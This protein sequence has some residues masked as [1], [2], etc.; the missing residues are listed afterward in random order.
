MLTNEQINKQQKA[1]TNRTR[2]HHKEVI[3]LVCLITKKYKIHNLAQSPSEP[4]TKNI[5]TRAFAQQPL[6]FGL[7][8]TLLLVFLAKD[9]YLR[10]II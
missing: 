7:V 5:S 3:I 9:N 4:Y 1:L 10:R 8:I 2:E 6:N